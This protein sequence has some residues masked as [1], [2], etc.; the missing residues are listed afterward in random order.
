MTKEEETY[1]SN[2]PYIAWLRDT[3]GL[4]KRTI[5]EYFYYYQHFIKINP[6]QENI[7][8][9]LQ[10]RKNNTVVRSFLK[11]L[12]EFLDKEHLF[13]IPKAASGTT[14]KRIVRDISQDQIKAISKYCYGVSL[15]EGLLFDILYYGALRREEITT[16]KINS[17]RWEEYF[18]N[19]LNNAKMLVTGKGKRQREVLIPPTVITKLL[20]EYLKKKFIHADMEK[21]DIIKVLSTSNIPLLRGLYLWRIWKNIKRNSERAIGIAVRPHELRHTRATELEKRG[22]SIRAIQHY[23]GHT[24]MATTEIYLHKSGE[25]STENIKEKLR[26]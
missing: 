23:L 17:F 22:V 10:K 20:N 14:K 1:H 13:K 7:N 11:S 5:T 4:A 15:R 9:F 12:L 21:A 2:H 6:T 26:K 25:E 19:P 24:N 16:I 8:A 18:K 3:K